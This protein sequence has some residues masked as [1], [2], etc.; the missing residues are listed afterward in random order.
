MDATQS[1]TRGA[2]YYADCSYCQINW[3]LRV[4]N[5]VYDTLLSLL[6]L[7]RQNAKNLNAHEERLATSP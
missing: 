7:F 5:D 2:H 4:A 3:E 6:L 1:A